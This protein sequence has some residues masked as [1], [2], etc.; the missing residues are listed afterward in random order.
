MVVDELHAVNQVPD[1]IGI[2]R[3]LDSQGI[4]DRAARGHR[5]YHGTDAANALGEGPG[6]PGIA[7]FHDQLDSPELRRGG[8]GFN[9]PAIIGLHLD[10]QVAFDPGDGIHDDLVTAMAASSGQAFEGGDPPGGG[11]T[12]G[13]WRFRSRA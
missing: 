12:T 13:S 9:D 5:V 3:N 4:L 7:A 8:P 6:I 1:Q 11:S 10:A 2:G